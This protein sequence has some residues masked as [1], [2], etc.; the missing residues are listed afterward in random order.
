MMHGHQGGGS[1]MLGRVKAAR[2]SPQAHRAAMEA[3]RDRQSK[4]Q[5]RRFTTGKERGV[6]VRQA[7]RPRMFM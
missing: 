7:R 5:V 2:P 6:V 4:T 1:K 3:D